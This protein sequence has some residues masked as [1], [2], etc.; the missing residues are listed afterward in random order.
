VP[1]RSEDLILRAEALIANGDAVI[2]THRADPPNVIGFAT[3]DSGAFTE[4]QT[5]TLAFL[6]TWAGKVC[7]A[8]AGENGLCA[9]HRDPGRMRELGRRGGHERARRE[10]G[11]ARAGASSSWLSRKTNSGRCSRT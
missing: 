3:L 5:Q 2:A 10:M 4:W 7:R 11:F 1:Q 8:A 9:S 6:L